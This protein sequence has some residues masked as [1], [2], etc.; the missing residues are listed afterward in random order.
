M[1]IFLKE[2]DIENINSRWWILEEGHGI[3]CS[4]KWSKCQ[5]FLNK[6]KRGQPFDGPPPEFLF[7]QILDLD[8]E[9]E[10]Y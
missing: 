5:N 2:Y 4:K 6:L 9:G 8:D 10:T 1:S 3:V 7:G